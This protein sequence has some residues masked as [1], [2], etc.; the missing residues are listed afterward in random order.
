V[1]TEVIFGGGVIAKN[2]EDGGAPDSSYFDLK[3][4]TPGPPSDGA[5]R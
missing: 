3:P 4:N 2:R 1:N 5:T